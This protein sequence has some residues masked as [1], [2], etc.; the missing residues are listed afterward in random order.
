MS[1]AEGG[2]MTR[3]TH[4]AQA[5]FSLVELMVVVAVA[6][7]L[8]SM[9]VFQIGVSRPGYIGDGAMRV[10]LSQI[11][12]ARE[13]AITQ[14]RNMRVDFTLGNKVTITRENIPAVAPL[15]TVIQSVFLEGGMEFSLVTG[16]PALPDS[17]DAFGN[18]TAT[19][20]SLA[21]TPATEVK[22]T[23]EGTMVNQDGL[24][25]NG[26]VFVALPNAMKDRKMSARVVTVFGSTGR[27]R[28]FK[29]DGV[30]WKPV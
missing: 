24:T 20:F 22:F 3:V 28:G 18:A 10:V 15:T 23:T 26:S 27:I 13:M 2:G 1:L 25:L 12:Q 4:R 8:T 21:G 7:V 11:T 9:A 6:G 16:P 5:G 19:T 14:R 29:W 17:P 30:R